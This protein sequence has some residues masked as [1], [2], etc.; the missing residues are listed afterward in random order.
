M[1]D[2]TKL[3]QPKGKPYLR[4]VGKTPVGLVKSFPAV[5]SEVVN[6]HDKK[7]DFSRI[8]FQDLE[9]DWHNLLFHG[10]NKEIMGTLLSNGFRGKIDLIYIDPPFDSGA[11]YVR[12]VILRGLKTKKLSGE[13]YTLDE[14][15]QYTDIWANDNYLQFMYERLLIMQELMSPDGF[16]FLHCDYHQGH[17]LKVLMDEVFDKSNFRNE[18]IA[19]RVQKNFAEEEYVTRMNN[20]YDTVLLY[21]NSPAPKFLPPREKMT[22]EDNKEEN[23]HGF[24]APNWSGGRQN[25]IYELF[26][27]Y[28]PPGNVWRWTKERA[29]EGIKLGIVRKNP[30][31][32]K[33]EYLVTNN[34]GTM[35]NNL[36]VDIL[37][38]AF[39][40]NYPTEKSEKLLSRIIEI[41]TE[42]DALVFDAFVGSGTT[43]AVAQK[44]GRRWIGIEINKGGIQTTSKRIQRILNGYVDTEEDSLSV[45][46]N[47]LEML[48]FAIYKVNDYDLQVFH[49][50]AMELAVEQIGVKRSK[51][52]VFFDGTR[53]DNLVKIIDFNHPLTLL[54]LQLIQDEIAKRPEENRNITIVCLGAETT[55]DSYVS[56]Y[57]KK[58]G[59]NKF[60]MIELRTDTKYGKL[61]VHKPDEAKISIERTSKETAVIK[62]EDF[63]SPTII[64]RLKSP[65]TLADVKIPDFRS[66]IDIVLI[67]YDYDG[68]VFNVRFSDVPEKKDDLINGTYNIRIPKTATRIAVKIIDMLGEEVIVTKEV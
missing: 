30:K 6:P 41:T 51:T 56:D 37:A 42:K 13:E 64:E 5:L 60:Q 53:G 67:D 29:F 27:H 47:K 33:P 58:P 19:K 1:S 36:W 61:F 39:R 2:K 17:Y 28:P 46:E 23:W 62:I 21:S 31:T 14:Q 22:E 57:N 16:I 20:A 12:K 59:V 35:V 32:G 18:I 4:W 7:K 66:M 49:R 54:D 34:K 52:D 43:C 3:F 63:I 48:S 45:K 10:D 68:S 11:D 8:T 44:L 26:D 50:E 55:V 9:Q 15:I 40:E 38:Y 65:D 24:D 25:L